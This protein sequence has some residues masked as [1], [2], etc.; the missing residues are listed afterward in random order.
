LF[1]ID[2]LKNSVV[3]TSDYIKYIV[4]ALLLILIIFK[5]YLFFSR[6]SNRRFENWFF[7]SSYALYNSRS[8]KSRKSKQFQNKL[9]VFIISI[10]VIDIIIFVLFRG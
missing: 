7:Y 9:T 5:T 6:T 4:T 1:A 8:D 3:M 2:D 10:A